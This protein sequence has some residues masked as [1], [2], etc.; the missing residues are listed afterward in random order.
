MVDGNRLADIG[1][2]VQTVAEAAGL[3]VVREYVGHAIGTAMHEKPEVPNYGPAGQ[4]PKLRAGNVFAVEP[5]VNL[6]AAETRCSTTAGPSSPPT[7]RC[8]PTSSTPSP[9]PTT[10]PRS[11]PCPGGRPRDTRVSHSDRRGCGSGGDVRAGRWWRVGHAGLIVF[12][13]AGILVGVPLADA[14]PAEATHIRASQLTWDRVPG[15]NDYTFHLFFVARR[16]YYGSP[17]VGSTIS[18]PGLSF[19]DGAAETPTLT[20]TFVDSAED[21]LTAEADVQHHYASA[22]PF[23]VVFQGCCRLS[24]TSEHVNNPDSGFPHRDHRIGGVH[25]QR[26]QFTGS[27]RWSCPSTGT[28]SFLVPASLPAGSTPPLAP[29]HGERSRGRVDPTRSAERTQPASDRRHG[30]GV[31][32]EHDRGR[33]ARPRS[34]V[35]DAGRHRGAPGR[36]RGLRTAVDFFIRLGRAPDHPVYAA[37]GDSYSSGEGLPSAYDRHCG[38]RRAARTPTWRPRPWSRNTR[39]NG[40]SSSS[41]AV[42][43][44]GAR[45]DQRP[46]RSGR[47]DRS[48]RPAPASDVAHGRRR[49]SDHAHGGGNASSCPVG[50]GLR[51]RLRCDRRCL[52][53]PPQRSGR[54]LLED[55]GEVRHSTT[56][57]PGSARPTRRPRSQFS[58]TR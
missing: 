8:R 3:S 1:H 16:S 39:L 30:G 56:C 15:T 52:H 51:I 46:A 9:S 50:G 33:S 2:A 10:A 34:A 5:M 49:P 55:P 20:V 17:S 31:L 58:A 35:L 48:P 45:D 40:R 4:G 22:G 18:D 27:G 12:V 7:A 41:H 26:H 25:E 24:S 19:G 42:A 14:P 54:D 43:R 38:R 28:C 23:T 57:T 47:R 44:E 6:G 11:S 29:R 37:L 53:P 32:L 36:G 21:V 13:V